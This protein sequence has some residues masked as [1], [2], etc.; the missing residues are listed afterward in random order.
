M[1]HARLKNNHLGVVCGEKLYK[2]LGVAFAI[3]GTVILM[4]AVIFSDHPMVAVPAYIYGVLCCAGAIGGL[5][6]A[7]AGGAR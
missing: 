1:E 6:G 4:G 3:H 5:A 7:T 2:G